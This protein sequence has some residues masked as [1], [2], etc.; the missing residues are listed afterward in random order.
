MLGYSTAE[1]ESEVRSSVTED[2]LAAVSVA[3]SCQH[4][5]EDLKQF[6]PCK[7]HVLHDVREAEWVYDS[8]EGEEDEGEAAKKQKRDFKYILRRSERTTLYTP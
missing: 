2:G 5:P 1:N 7:T 3:H 8:E 6:S 4:L